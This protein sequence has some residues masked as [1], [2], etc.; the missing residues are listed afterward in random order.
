M[1]FSGDERCYYGRE[2]R[3]RKEYEIERNEAGYNAEYAATRVSHVG[4]S[5]EAYKHYAAGRCP[6]GQIDA[7]ARRYAVKLF[8]AHM[9]GV[10][11]ER[12][13]GK[14]APKPY[15]IA[16]LGHVHEK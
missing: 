8:L 7:R 14:P 12:H 5:T 4:K 15:P 1:K 11:Y 6:P 3:V 9:H 2:Y 16:I 13:F 10:W